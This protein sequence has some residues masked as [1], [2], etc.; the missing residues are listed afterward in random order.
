MNKNTSEEKQ[1]FTGDIKTDSNAVKNAFGGSFDLIAREIL[2]G[3]TPIYI[4]IIDGMCDEIKIIEG[5]IKPLTEIYPETNSKNLN[6]KIQKRLFKGT[7][8]KLLRTVEDAAL[9]IIMGNLVLIA[10]G[11]TEAVSF[12]LQGF[13]KKS[14]SEPQTEQNERGAQEAFTDN[15]KDNT[16]LLRRKLRT[17]N[18]T[19]RH[20]TLGKTSNTPTLICYLSDRVSRELLDK[21]TKRIDKI[22]L[23]AI[24]GSGYIQPFLDNRRPSFFTDTGITE[25]PDTFASML[26]EG[27]VGIIVDG[28][29]FALI[30]PYLFIDYFHAVDDYLSSPYYALFMRI[31]R[32]VCFIIA[33]TLPGTFVAICLF[34]P[35]IMPADIMYGISAAT[36]RTPFPI[37]IEALTIHF[38]YEIVREAGLRM[39]R[40]V[41]HA[42]S[43]V[44]ALVIG[45]AAVTAGLIAAPMLIIVALTAI[46]SSVIVKLHEPVAIM[47]FGFILIGGFTGLYG[48][49]L[50]IG[51]MLIDICSVSP[52]GI[53]FSAPVSPFV[54]KAQSDV[55]FRRNW[56]KIKN[57]KLIQGMKF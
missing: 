29:P 7:S 10:D 56:T 43:I 16:T 8:V 21:I 38:I 4:F 30:V 42:V 44:G 2:F 47:R 25:R 20:I 32:I 34:H 52:Y 1:Y 51:L 13:P 18:L 27:R 9:D 15:F 23:D 31:L 40:S 3:K 22:D 39:P 12:P 35:E 45:D 49:M 57:K 54:L 24:L 55:F 6:E 11:E 5:V 53:P 46:S 17:P 36:S 48:I 37:M 28:T 50:G 26:L 41:G 19:I 33:S 14:V